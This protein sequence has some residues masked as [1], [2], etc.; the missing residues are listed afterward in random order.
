MSRLP[1]NSIQSPKSQ[2]I[3]DTIV[4]RLNQLPLQSQ[5]QVLD[6]VEFLLQR[7]KLD[8]AVEPFNDGVEEDLTIWEA[9]EDED[10]LALEAQ[11]SVQK[12]K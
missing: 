4:Q 1:D 5:H 3:A 9:A 2:T 7:H 10:W 12:D 11:L 6:F 8:K